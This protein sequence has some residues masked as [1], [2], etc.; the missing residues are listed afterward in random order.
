MLSGSLYPSHPR[1]NGE[2]TFLVLQL[3]NL[4]KLDEKVSRHLSPILEAF[5]SASVGEILTVV[6]YSLW[7]ISREFVIQSTW[8]D[9]KKFASFSNGD[10]YSFHLMAELLF[11]RISLRFNWFDVFFKVFLQLCLCLQF[12]EAFLYFSLLSVQWRPYWR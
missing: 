5:R 4:E 12:S 1:W 3:D 2:S 6:N 7:E 10:P 11:D 8:E 9:F